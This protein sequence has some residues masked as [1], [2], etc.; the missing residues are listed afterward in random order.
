[1]TARR[2]L[3]RTCSGFLAVLLLAGEISAQTFDAGQAAY[4]AGQY[5]VAIENWEPLS[6]QGDARAQA[7][8]GLMYAK[9]LGVER[10]DKR[11]I[12]LFRLSAE[13][14]FVDAQY[15]LGIGY[16]NGLG[17][18]RDDWVAGLWFRRAADQGHAKASAV[19]GYLLLAKKLLPVDEN[20]AFTRI[21]FAAKAGEPPAQFNLGLM[22]A[23]GDGAPQDFVTAYMWI[24]IAK[25]NGLED[26]DTYLRRI[27]NELSAEELE[28]A[29]ARAVRCRTS[30]YA[31][32]E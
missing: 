13:Q 3:L 24:E 29:K 16:R 25:A 11:A 8:L 20:E 27:E 7:S 22:H 4:E 32:C 6:E 18:P 12:Q 17:V 5:Q 19:L 1:M 28:D 2:Y 9:G 23:G 21:S 30:D 10:D 14:G 26:T 15:Y 31:D